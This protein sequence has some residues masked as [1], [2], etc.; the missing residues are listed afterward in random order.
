[1][2]VL[3]RTFSRSTFELLKGGFKFQQELRIKP[4]R[5]ITQALHLKLGTSRL[6]SKDYLCPRYVEVEGSATQIKMNNFLGRLMK[7]V[8]KVSEQLGF[9]YL[10]KPYPQRGLVA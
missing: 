2:K 8:R 6:F 3:E 5:S 10:V 4:I 7:S 1:M 9:V